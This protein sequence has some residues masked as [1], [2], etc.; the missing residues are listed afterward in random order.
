MIALMTSTPPL[1]PAGWYPDPA[2]GGGERFWDGEAWSQS[3]RDPRPAQPPYAVPERPQ[4][5]QPPGRWQENPQY[6]GGNSFQPY[7]R[8]G[9]V[10][11][12]GGV[13]LATFWPRAGGFVIDG[14]IL[15]VVGMVVRLFIGGDADVIFQRYLEH[16]MLYSIN[17]GEGPMPA[18]PTAAIVEMAIASLINLLIFA[19]Y[20][21]VLLGTMSA[22]LGQK[23]FGLKA[24]KLGDES[25]ANLGWTDAILRGA[26]GAV[27]YNFIPIFMQITVLVTS[28]KQTVPD[29]LSKTVVINTREA[30]S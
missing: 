4:T 11:V 22:T 18:L 28:R 9:L 30:R 20:R 26:L 6:Q 10:P 12:Q 24:V 16:L 13:P 15:W 25:N 17:G 7:Q 19:A 29:L 5:S 27:L 21:S 14:L 1:P 23:V 3:T 8:Q 2:G